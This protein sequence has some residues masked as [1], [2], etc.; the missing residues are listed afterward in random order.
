MAPSVGPA[1]GQKEQGCAPRVAFIS[2]QLGGGSAKVSELP[3]FL[4]CLQIV[5]LSQCLQLFSSAAG[6]KHHRVEL[7]WFLWVVLLILLRVIPLGREC[8]AWEGWPLQYGEWLSTGIPF[9]QFSPQSPTPDSPHISVV[10]PALPLLV[11]RV[12]GYKQNF[13]HWSF[14]RLSLSL[15][16]SSWWTETLLLFTTVCYLD[17]FPGFGAGGWGVWLGV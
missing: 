12:S 1:C 13:M 15:A 10:H 8:S 17:S 4:L 7:E 2:S 14:K 16:I 6:L 3:E 9:P 5:R 11:S